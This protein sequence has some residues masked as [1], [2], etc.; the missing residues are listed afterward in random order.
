MTLYQY[1]DGAIFHPAYAEV[2][3]WSAQAWVVAPVQPCYIE[4]C[5]Y[6][7]GLPGHRAEG[8]TERAIDGLEFA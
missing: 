6:T 4:R 8:I 2:Y 3:V 1:R 7:G 5:A